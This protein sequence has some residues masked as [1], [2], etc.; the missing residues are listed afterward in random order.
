M[1]VN[2][3][4]IKERIE[5][6]RKTIN[7]HRYLYHI[8]NKQE[9]SD[10]A[11][12]SL[13]HN[14]FK[15]EQEYPEFITP[16]SPTQRVVGGVLKG[17]KKVAHNQRML[18]LEDVFNEEEF[19]DWLE[20]IEKL[21]SQKIN[22]LFSETKFDG[23]AVSLI[24]KNGILERAA[25]RGDGSVGEDITQNIKTIESV[26]LRLEVLGKPEGKI[27]KILKKIIESKEIEIRGE[28]VILKKVFL[29]INEDREKK[30][31]SIYANPRNLAAGSVR[32]LDPKITALRKLDFFGWDIVGN[33]GQ[34]FHS[35][36]HEIME[37]LGFK[38]DK[39]SKI[40]KNSKE[41]FDLRK[42]IEKNREFLEYEIDGIV[43]SV[44]ENKI[45]EN[46]GVH[47]KSPRGSI[48]F[49]FALREATAKVLDISPQV[50]R[51][52][53]L[54]PAAILQPVSLSGVV[55]SRATLHNFDEVRRLG[56]K[57]GDTVIVGRAGDVIPQ[58]IKVLPEMRIGTEKEVKIPD[59]CPVCEE[60]VK[61]D[62]GGVYIKCVNLNC[63]AKKREYLYYFVSK[64]GFDIPG[65]GPRII[66]ALYDNALIQD[67]SDF[68][69]LEK[70]DLLPLER[71]A[72][73][74]AENLLNA[75]QSHREISFPKL[76]TALGIL[77]VG[78]QTALDLAKKFKN[79]Y[80]LKNASL[81]DLEN[82]QNIGTVVSKSAYDWFRDKYNIKFLDKLLREIKIEE[83]KSSGKLM[84]KTF[85]LTGSLES[86]PRE[87]AKEKIIALGGEASETVSKKIDYVIV[88]NDPGNK[89]DKAKKMGVKIL[90]E[91]EFLNML[92][93]Y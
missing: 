10:E 19:N 39:Y 59:I 86:M 58:I 56:V 38:S 50:G 3:Q 78:E 60:K 16:D 32:Q 15:L 14:L 66:N 37:F 17:F 40:C 55:I 88:G 4:E 84:G 21:H 93:N 65:L 67:A 48:A 35:E 31:L 45:F 13:K 46:L 72:D 7:H 22:N 79:I 53:V 36:E 75:I 71:F 92:Q 51:T 76:I 74:S 49:K 41:V 69:K 33:F 29:K 9:I 82:I 43:V 62:S 83:V 81:A 8:L 30:G 5:K 90:S 61:K 34:E 57:I 24:Y 28:V 87:E 1:K 6:L 20:R 77:H 47:G 85:V 25:T 63:P 11:L 18:S 91:K 26:P 44:N 54:T 23:L 73:K 64:K 42:L 27:E 12:D 70:G 2:K 68:F 80:N 89:L 52:G